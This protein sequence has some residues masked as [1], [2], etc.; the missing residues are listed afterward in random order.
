MNCTTRSKLTM[1]QPNMLFLQLHNAWTI[2]QSYYIQNRKCKALQIQ[3]ITFTQSTHINHIFPPRSLINDL[4]NFLHQYTPGYVYTKALT[5]IVKQLYR[6]QQFP[7]T[8]NALQLLLS[9]TIFNQEMKGQWAITFVN[10]LQHVQE[11]IPQVP[12]YVNASHSP[13]QCMNSWTFSDFWNFSKHHSKSCNSWHW[14]AHFST[15]N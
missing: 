15:K 10:T 8:I 1:S 4:P 5:E 14:Q 7:L 13:F 2:Y 3:C 12:S 11:N 6:H 9:Q